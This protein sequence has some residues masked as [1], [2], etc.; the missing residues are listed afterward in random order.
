MGCFCL[1]SIH[2]PSSKKS[3]LT[4]IWHQ[5]WRHDVGH[6]VGRKLP[7][8][9]TWRGP[10]WAQ[11]PMQ[12]K[13]SWQGESKR[14]PWH[15]L[16]S[17]FCHT[18]ELSNYVHQVNPFFFVSPL[19]SC[20]SDTCEQKGGMADLHMEAESKPLLGTHRVQHLR[21]TLHFILSKSRRG[22]SALVQDWNR[23]SLMQGQFQN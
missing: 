16:A 14:V 9:V 6:S 1:T 3:S 10:A 12:G 15:R 4:F 8:T 5:R 17:A 11:S 7:G 23:F 2:F 13:Q 21:R 22:S 20:A 19:E 18:F